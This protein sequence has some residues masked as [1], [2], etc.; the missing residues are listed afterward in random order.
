MLDYHERVLAQRSKTNGR[1]QR[2][3]YTEIQDKCSDP[4][5]KLPHFF[6]EPKQPHPEAEERA[7]EPPKS[8]T[9]AEETEQSRLKSQML[10]RHALLNAAATDTRLRQVEPHR[11]EEIE[12]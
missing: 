11:Q 6:K 7:I 2:L 5:R 9:A 12:H 3:Q 1:Y 10:A 8:A 4:K